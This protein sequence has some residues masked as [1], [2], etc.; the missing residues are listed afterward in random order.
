MDVKIVNVV[1]GLGSQMMAYGLSKALKQMAPTSRVIC[2]FSAYHEFGGVEH[3][4]PELNRVFGITEDRTPWP[5]SHVLHSSRIHYRAIRKALLYSSV[6]KIHS[7]E[8]KAYNYDETVFAQKGFVQYHQCWTSWLYLEPVKHE[9]KKD[10]AFPALSSSDKSNL[11]LLESIRR[12]QS[13]ALHV[14]LGD[15]R[16]SKILGGV[17]GSQYYRKA[18]SVI[19]REVRNPHFFVF[20]NEPSAALHELGLN[21]L[22]CDVVSCNEAADSWKDMLLM[23]ECK[24]HVIPNSSFS[25]WGAYLS[26]NIGQVVVAPRIWANPVSGIELRDMNLPSWT[27]VDNGHQ[28]PML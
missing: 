12:A 20:Y 26:K 17:V 7:A 28:E 21:D 3:N 18:I 25:W 9:L 27:I 10:F 23:S 11:A 6:L 13:V 14:R 2:D 4:G 24:H 8:E 1:G 15:Y 19:C 5:L 22:P 16:K